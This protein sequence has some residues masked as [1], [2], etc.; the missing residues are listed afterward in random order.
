MQVKTQDQQ[1]WCFQHIM[2]SFCTYLFISIHG[3]TLLIFMLSLTHLIMPIDNVNTQTIFMVL[4][5]FWSLLTLGK[6]LDAS[7]NI[8]PRYLSATYSQLTT[9]PF[10]YRHHMMT[11]YAF[12]S[13]GLDR[14]GKDLAPL[15]GCLTICLPLQ[16]FHISSITQS[17][18]SSLTSLKVWGEKQ[19]AHHVYHLHFDTS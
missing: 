3:R 2:V 18:L 14:W 10:F 6:P 5:T 13:Q 1:H 7:S 12:F 19:K 9:S 4:F 15:V 8:S 16:Q 17:E 11:D